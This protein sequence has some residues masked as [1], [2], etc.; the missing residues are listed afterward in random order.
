ME[1]CK[2]WALHR[3]RAPLPMAALAVGKASGGYSPSS[4]EHLRTVELRA[5]D[6][7]VT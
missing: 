4:A 7:L 3:A 2:A 6:A 1:G 5:G